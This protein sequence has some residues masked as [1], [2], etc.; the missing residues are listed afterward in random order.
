MIA[1]DRISADDSQKSPDEQKDQK[2]EAQQ[3]DTGVDA[4]AWGD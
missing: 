4:F 3:I 2:V 1:A